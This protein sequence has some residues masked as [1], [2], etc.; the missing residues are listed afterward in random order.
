MIW[1]AYYLAIM[2]LWGFF[3]GFLLGGVSSFLAIVAVMGLLGV[4]AKLCL[5][6]RNVLNKN[7][8]RG[9]TIIAIL[10]FQF[11]IL[12]LVSAFVLD[13]P[14]LLMECQ[15]TTLPTRVPCMVLGFDLG[16]FTL[17]LWGGAV[18]GVF[19]LPVFL[20]LSAVSLGYVI[21]K[22][23]TG[24]LANRARRNSKTLSP[25]PEKD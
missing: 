24:T 2:L 15:I 6:L 17:G 18:F 14:A 16:A 22:K 20:I 10:S 3:A 11:A 19:T 1:L 7:E 13:I 21:I 5:H 8:L 4:L 23:I 12:P 9:Y 25:N